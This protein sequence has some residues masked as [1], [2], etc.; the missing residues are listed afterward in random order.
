MVVIAAAVANKRSA[1]SKKV[2]TAAPTPPSKQP[3][4]EADPVR[5]APRPPKCVKKLA[6]KGEWEIHV[7]SSQT[8]ETTNPDAPLAAHV[9]QVLSEQRPISTG[10]ASQV[11]PISES[12]ESTAV[13]TIPEAVE[14]TAALPTEEPAAPVLTVAPV[15]EKEP[16]LV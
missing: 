8:T 1:L 3:R 13:S 2:D 16:P 5:E 6:Q 11:R 9:A 14:P 4:Q 7:I 10:R 15:L 12:V